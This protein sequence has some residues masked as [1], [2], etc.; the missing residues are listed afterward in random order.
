MRLLLMA[1]IMLSASLG[2]A[3]DISEAYANELIEINITGL[4]YSET[5]YKD[6]DIKIGILNLT[7][8][9]VE[10]TARPG[11]V[12]GSAEGDVQDMILTEPLHMIAS[13]ESYTEDAVHAMCIQ[14]SN[15]SPLAESVFYAKHYAGGSMETL[16]EFIHDNQYQNHMGQEAMWVLS[17]DH[18]VYNITGYAD[19]AN[20][21]RQYVADLTGVFFDT[22]LVD[23]QVNYVPRTHKE[24]ALYLKFY[25][26]QR[27]DIKLQVYNQKGEFDRDLMIYRDQEAGQYNFKY[28]I[29]L[30]GMLGEKYYVRLYVGEDMRN[31]FT[32]LIKD[33]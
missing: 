17:N 2:N 5:I 4:D 7:G 11:F 3:M 1:L 33:E 28:K 19:V 16:A 15:K 13:H 31:E 24:Y 27:E 32:L 10:I 9:S 12:F 22:S 29:S 8:G 25:L 18:S 26:Q 21:I 23:K 6:K 30:Y 14:S 20:P